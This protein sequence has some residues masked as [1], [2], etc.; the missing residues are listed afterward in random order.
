MKNPHLEPASGSINWPSITFAD[1]RRVRH[2]RVVA[3]V[4]GTTVTSV[5]L[6]ICGADRLILNS[7]AI[8]GG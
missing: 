8:A 7:S 5:D 6:R 4:C 3:Y 2:L 1:W